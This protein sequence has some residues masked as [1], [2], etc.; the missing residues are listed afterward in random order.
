MLGKSGD[1]DAGGDFERMLL[2]QER[3]FQ[4]PQQGLRRSCRSC[5]VCARKQ[6][7]ELVAAEPG[8]Q[9]LGL[10][11]FMETRTHLAKQ[12]IAHLV[13]EAVVDFFEVVD[14]EQKQHDAGIGGNRFL[15]LFPQHQA[16]REVGQA[17]MERVVLQ[18]SLCQELAPAQLPL[19]DRILDG[20][21]Q[22]CQPV[23]EDI[24][25]G[26]QTH[27]RN[28]QVFTDG[29][30]DDD[31]G[32]VQAHLLHDFQRPDGIELWLV[33]VGED[34]VEFGVEVGLEAGLVV[35]AAPVELV[36]GPA[37][38]VKGKLGVLRPVFQDQYAQ[39]SSGHGSSN[40][41]GRRAISCLGNQF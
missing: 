28:R 18:R 29:T 16:V 7:G 19:L 17:V 24:V 14:V 15:D 22:P 31:K 20:G 33:I 21:A 39:R 6:D 5:G 40:S 35:D 12:R 10:D 23:L 1:P 13:S 2:A 38:L 41:T 26:P 25:H 36:A 34:Q 30:R 8:D 3:P 27:G 11:R 9:V 32:D 37:E 4:R